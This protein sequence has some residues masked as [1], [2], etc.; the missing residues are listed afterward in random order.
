MPDSLQGTDEEQAKRDKRL[1]RF[2]AEESRAS[3]PTKLEPVLPV[4]SPEISIGRSQPRWAFVGR[5]RLGSAHDCRDVQ[6]PRK[7]VF[8]FN[9]G[10]FGNLFR[11]ASPFPAHLLI[12]ACS[13][14]NRYRE[15]RANRITREKKTLVQAPD[16]STVRPLHI[17]KQSLELLE[18]KWRTERNYAY[19]CDQFKSLRQDLTVS[20][21]PHIPIEGTAGCRMSRFP[22]AYAVRT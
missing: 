15:T 18:E 1:L 20:G 10:V 21:S 14:V 11:S 13:A 8:T 16:P 4:I 5:H 2:Q 7:A 6:Q 3:T 17:L 9:I 22:S 12:R 19:V